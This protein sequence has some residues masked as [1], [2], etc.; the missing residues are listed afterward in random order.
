[1]R[2]KQNELVDLSETPDQSVM[3]AWYVNEFRVERK[4]CLIFM[5]ER[6]LLSFILFGVRKSNTNKDLLPDM[7][8]EGVFQL[9]K[10]ERFSLESISR[11]IEDSY[12]SRYAKTDSRKVLGNM[13]E[14]AATY[15]HMIWHEG[16]L[17][18][19][20][21][22]DLFSRVNRTPQRN[23]G[24]NYSIDIARELL[25]APAPQQSV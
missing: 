22:N 2:L 8:L 6:T 4:K 13:N 20:D 12:E 10:L 3:G 19:C 21:L 5:N 14:L 18:H 23:L 16:G 11:I 7:C 24:W 17:A 15:E 1:M 25:G 9:L